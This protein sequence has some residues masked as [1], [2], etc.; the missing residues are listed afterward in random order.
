VD[1][2]KIGLIIYTCVLFLLII[3]LGT[4]IYIDKEKIAQYENQLRTYKAS[5]EMRDI[6]KYL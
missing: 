3:L 1:E 6:K 2:I 4:K 5:D